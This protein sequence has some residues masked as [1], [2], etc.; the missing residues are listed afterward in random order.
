MAAQPS[1]ASMSPRMFSVMSRPSRVAR[2]RARR[3]RPWATWPLSISSIAP[4]YSASGPAGIALTTESSTALDDGG[5]TPS[6]TAQASS[7]L[8]LSNSIV[9]SESSTS[10]ASRQRPPDRR[11]RGGPPSRQRVACGG[12]LGPDRPWPFH[13]RRSPARGRT[14]HPRQPPAGE[15]CRSWKGESTGL[16]YRTL[17]GRPKCGP[18]LADRDEIPHPWPRW[19]SAPLGP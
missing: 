14:G 10:L 1:P 8:A 5:V 17:P 6:T 11:A 12:G 13:R 7:P 4:A 15:G 19:I 3:L 18:T 16:P 2:A 9:L